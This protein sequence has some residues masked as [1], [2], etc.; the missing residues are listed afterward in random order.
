MTTITPDNA[1]SPVEWLEYGEGACLSCG[2]AVFGLRD[3]ATGSEVDHCHGCG[4]VLAVVVESNDGTPI[5]G[6]MS[7]EDIERTYGPLPDDDE[8]QDAPY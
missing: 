5:Q 1:A 2:G 8:D 3:S 6:F 7:V 4:Q